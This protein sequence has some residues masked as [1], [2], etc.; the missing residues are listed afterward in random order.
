[1]LG[2]QPL[3]ANEMLRE[4]KSEK[5]P[6]GPVAPATLEDSLR[7]GLEAARAQH[8]GEEPFNP[9]GWMHSELSD[10]TATAGELSATF[11]SYPPLPEEMYYAFER[12]RDAFVI[13]A[14]PQL[15]PYDQDIVR[16]G[17]ERQAVRVS[18]GDKGEYKDEYPDRVVLPD[19]EKPLL[20]LI[21]DVVGVPYDGEQSVFSFAPILGEERLN[22]L[23]DEDAYLED[24]ARKNGHLY[25]YKEWK[26]QWLGEE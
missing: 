14:Y 24:L 3:F 20:K 11:L 1:M 17:L 8:N 12:L 25:S 6:E 10:M 7:A 19:E 9:V 23:L 22:I 15:S 2:R 16:D 4:G 13:C 18:G 21:T 26:K 5:M